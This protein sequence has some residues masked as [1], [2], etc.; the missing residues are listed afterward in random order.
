[1]WQLDASRC[2]WDYHGRSYAS[3]FGCQTRKDTVL[4]PSHE[5]CSSHEIPLTTLKDMA[6]DFWVNLQTGSDEFRRLLRKR[7]PSKSE[8]ED[9]AGERWYVSQST[10]RVC[11]TAWYPQT[12]AISTMHCISWRSCLPCFIPFLYMCRC[13]RLK[14]GC[15]TNIPEYTLFRVP[16]LAHLHGADDRH[17]ELCLA[18]GSILALGSSWMRNLTWKISLRLGTITWVTLLPVGLETILLPRQL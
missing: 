11:S 9:R 16:I 17:T 4:S 10:A 6:A 7:T 2:L 12:Y 3:S 14:L 18:V 15:V 5:G 8:T 13:K 1:M